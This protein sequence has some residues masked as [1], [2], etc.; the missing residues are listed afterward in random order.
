VETNKTPEPVKACPW[1]DSAL[2]RHRKVK[3]NANQREWFCYACHKPFNKPVERSLKSGG[4]RANPEDM[5]TLTEEEMLTKLATYNPIRTPD[6]PY[7][8]VSR[9]R[10]LI[11]FL[12][13]AG[14][15]IREVLGTLDTPQLELRHFEWVKPDEVLVT[16][17]ILKAR[18][19]KNRKIPIIKGSTRYDH[20]FFDYLEKF[21][22]P[23]Y[24]NQKVLE[25]W[26]N[27]PLFPIKRSR[28]HQIAKQVLGS[29]YFPHFMRHQC[30]STLV[31]KYDLSDT[32]AVKY[33]GWADTRHMG[34]YAHL[35][36]GEL[37]DKMRSKIKK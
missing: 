30:V 9:D 11:V 22:K 27:T 15:R 7:P 1:C 33:M 3:D 32:Q 6:N 36:T 26:K 4:R 37:S 8:H 31:T 2:V 13:L 14:P 20:Y 16:L 5:E 10:A 25:T 34:R 28:A 19:R 18:K 12:D 35:R 21:G 23:D 17:P 29:T 24:S